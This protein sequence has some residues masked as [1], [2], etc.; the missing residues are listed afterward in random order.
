M[1]NTG[2]TIHLI[3]TISILWLIL[4]PL[5]VIW[6]KRIYHVRKSLIMKKR[7]IDGSL[8]ACFF[9]FAWL[10]FDFPLNFFD[11]YF[12]ISGYENKTSFFIYQCV[13][14]WFYPICAQGAVYAL[15]YRFWMIYFEFMYSESLEH[16]QWKVHINPQGCSSKEMWI[17]KHRSD[18]GNPQWVRKRLAVVYVI[19]VLF[20]D[21]LRFLSKLDLFDSGTADLIDSALYLI[22]LI[23]IF[24]LWCKMPAF[25][26]SF[27]VRDELKWV[28]ITY[29]I[30]LISNVSLVTYFIINDMNAYWNEAVWFWPVFFVC[31]ALIFVQTQYILI[32]IQKN[33]SYFRNILAFSAYERSHTDL[34]ISGN[35]LHHNNSHDNSRSTQQHP[36]TRVKLCDVL[37]DKIKFNLFMHH[38]STE[39]STECLYSFIE[40]TQFQM[41]LQSDD[42]F[43]ANIKP[44][45][46]TPQPAGDD[47]LNANGRP[48]R[49]APSKSKKKSKDCYDKVKLL[50]EESI[51]LSHIVFVQEYDDVNSK[52]DRYKRV[53]I[54]LGHKYIYDSGD[55]CININYNTRLDIVEWINTFCCQKDKAFELK[56]YCEM[57]HLFE[58]C[59]KEMY[60]LMQHT[61]ARFVR[62][63]AFLSLN[64][65]LE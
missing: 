45:M 40:F 5:C 54:A 7:Y 4:L 61:L 11:G 19:V 20:T 63:N 23:T 51:P 12:L 29:I 30:A 14:L 55:F 25:A 49:F 24:V 33:S 53:V 47:T 15:L 39:L 31:F 57:Y 62:T 27:M 59:R 2:A 43:M 8:Y 10:F 35:S 6:I 17:I 26:D 16:Q 50:D 1:E 34:S 32:R 38:I 44:Q 64:K 56:Q 22:P 58:K 41:L 21:I 37:Q 48:C 9:L 42:M 60:K 36:K 65:Q 18:Y 13:Q 46:L 28:I 3:A 52:L